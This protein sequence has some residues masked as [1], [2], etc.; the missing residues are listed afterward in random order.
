MKKK[1]RSTSTESL[2]CIGHWYDATGLDADVPYKICVR[3]GDDAILE[4]FVSDHG[5]RL[6]YKTIIA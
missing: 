2:T 3:Q 5:E 6:T 4:P 1:K